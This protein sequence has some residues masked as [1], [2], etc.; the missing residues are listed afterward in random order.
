MTTTQFRALQIA[1]KRA[2]EAHNDLQS[3]I[4][5]MKPITAMGESV[6]SNIDIVNNSQVLNKEIQD[7]NTQVSSETDLTKGQ[8]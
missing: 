6:M 2:K 8:Q 1:L 7:A 5:E 4:D 3:Q